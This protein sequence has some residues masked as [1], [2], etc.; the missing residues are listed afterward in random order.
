ME[1]LVMEYEW[2]EWIEHDGKSSP[3]IGVICQKE[4]ANG[5]ILVG[6]VGGSVTTASQLKVPRYQGETFSSSWFWGSPGDYV[7]I[8]RYR[9]RRPRVAEWLDQVTSD[10]KVDA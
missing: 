7:P 1:G 6:P 5:V 8:I 9:V 2:T 3:E 10:L 4:Y